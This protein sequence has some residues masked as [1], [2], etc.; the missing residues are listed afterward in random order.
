MAGWHHN[1]NGH[2][3]GQS[4]GDDEGQKGLVC[5]SREES[6]MTGG[7]NKYGQAFKQQCESA[8]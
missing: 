3:L 4:L 7:L 1:C 8:M 2:E 6:D 5:C